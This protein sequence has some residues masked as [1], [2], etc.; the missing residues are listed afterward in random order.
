MKVSSMLRNVFFMIMICSFFVSAQTG[1]TQ[2]WLNGVDFYQ[3]GNFEEAYRNFSLYEKQG[4]TNKDFYV[5][6][7][8]SAARAGY[9]D[10]IAILERGLLRY[11]GDADL[12]LILVQF[13]SREKR[14]S[15]AIHFLTKAKAH[16]LPDEYKR[17]MGILVFNQ[18]VLLYQQNK[19]KKSVPYFRKALSYQPGEAR[20]VRN[21]A[22][23]LWETERK[24]E[25]VKLLENS[26]RLFPDDRNMNRLLIEFYRKSNR[27]GKLQTKLEELA[28]KSGKLEDY[29]VL[30]QFYLQTGNSEKSKALF[31]MLEKKYPRQRKI[32]LIRTKFYG[33]LLQYKRVD[34][35]LSDMED[36]FPQ[37]TLVFRLKAENY[38]KMDSLQAAIRYWEKSVQKIPTKAEWHFRLLKDLF[39]T[40]STAYY[41]HLQEMEALL[42][43]P[44]SRL[45]MAMEWYRHKRWPKA[46]SLFK[47]ILQS[48]AHNPLALAYAGLC[49]RQLGRDSLSVHYFRQAIEQPSALPEAYFGLAR[50]EFMKAG[51]RQSDFYFAIGLEVLLDH[52]RQSQMTALKE[53]NKDNGLMDRKKMTVIADEY[54]DYEGLLKNEL[55]WFLKHHSRDKAQRFLKKL[56][57]RFPKNRFIRLALSDILS[58]EGNY[59]QAENYL[60]DVLF[61]HPGDPQAL[62][63]K[64]HLAQEQG[65]DEGLYRIYLNLLYHDKTNFT[66]NDFRHLIELAKKDGQIKNLARQ[67]LILYEHNG[68]NSL[69]KTYVVEALHLAGEHRKA[70]KIAAKKAKKIKNKE[71]RLI[72][73]MKSYN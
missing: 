39:K 28:H 38:E 42:T 53:L 13:L 47:N 2:Y 31:K 62:R 61:M 33:A 18:G 66:N 56:L 22:I 54:E 11:P 32:Y 58:E 59:R 46:L 65:K 23:V 19:K 49:N 35:V 8:M 51:P 26:V 73:L 30:G 40:D 36:H 50:M 55:N 9:G 6:F 10:Q 16:V 48:D 69:L 20:F 4:G 68:S 37:D 45:K 25:A 70:R 24:K 43:D 67:L 21:L 57:R 7:A 64:I 44:A 71:T 3:K 27:L 60:D 41:R 1:S 52:I 17:I 72:P 5:Y 12:T 63:R 34:R 14:F 15:E 29:L